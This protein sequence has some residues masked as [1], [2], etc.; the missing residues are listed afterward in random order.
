[1]NTVAL[2]DAERKNQNYTNKTIG[3]FQQNICG[4]M[5]SFLSL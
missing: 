5:E 4:N 3:M 2:A 1:M